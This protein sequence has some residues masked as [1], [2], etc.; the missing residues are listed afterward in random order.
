[1]SVLNLYKCTYQSEELCA[2]LIDLSTY[3]SEESCAERIDLR[4]YQSEE[5]CAE[6]LDLSTYQA[7]ELC[8]ELIDL[9]RSSLIWMD[10]YSLKYLNNSFQLLLCGKKVLLNH[11]RIYLNMLNHKHVFKYT[12]TCS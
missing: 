6:R 1:M 12:L 10:C 5:L 11:C 9:S 4:T 8:A 2:E 3:Q 7:D